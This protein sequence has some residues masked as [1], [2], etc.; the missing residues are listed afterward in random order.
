MS[1]LELKRSAPPSK[2]I[3]ASLAGSAGFYFTMTI[4]MKHIANHAGERGTRWLA[5]LPIAFLLIVVLMTWRGLSKMDELERKM[6]ME[7]MAYAFLGSLLIVVTYVCL[8]A[9]DF[10][11]PP[12][13][14]L[15]PLMAGCWVVSLVLA[16]ERYK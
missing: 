11:L 15:V 1:P 12:I 6:H 7:A 3:A 10:E 13:F 5:A 2:L 14:F 8:L 4:L 16:V 9:T